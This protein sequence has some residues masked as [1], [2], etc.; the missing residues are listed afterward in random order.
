MASLTTCLAAA[1]DLITSEV[2]AALHESARTLREGG[3]DTASA[4]KKAIE[5]H[6]GRIEDELKTIEKAA[7]D[8]ET[9]YSE[10]VPEKEAAAQPEQSAIEALAA[11]D[12]QMRVQLPGD[13][14]SMTIA[15]AIDRIK[16][17]QKE[18]LGFADLVR[19]AVQC[20]LTGG[21]AI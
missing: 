18:E 15:D 1:G 2:R 9:L 12:P 3:L 14:K 17:E 20:A 11:R 8:G 7:K 21:A 13:E 19:V 16:T 4:A 6:I 5:D 10:P